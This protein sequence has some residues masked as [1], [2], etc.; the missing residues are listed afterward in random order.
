MTPKGAPFSFTF[1]GIVITTTCAAVLSFFSLFLNNE[2]GIRKSGRGGTCSG[3]RSVPVLL[4][5]AP[6]RRRFRKGLDQHRKRS[7]YG[8]HGPLVPLLALLPLCIGL[9]APATATTGIVVLLLLLL[10]FNCPRKESAAAATSE[11][12]SPAKA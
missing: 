2:V 12:G 10:M 7:Q 4:A 1:V 11:L 3:G 6:G 9:F 5:P 8:Q